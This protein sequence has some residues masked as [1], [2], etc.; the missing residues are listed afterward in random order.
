MKININNN[1][2]LM[3]SYF[4]LTTVLMKKTDLIA[5]CLR[6]FIILNT[7]QNYDGIIT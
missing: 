3:D 7:W 2:S 1:I 5:I 6:F 4:Q